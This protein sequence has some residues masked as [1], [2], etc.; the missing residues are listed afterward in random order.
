MGLRDGAQGVGNDFRDIGYSEEQEGSEAC[1][2]RAIC[3]PG[4]FYSKWA[5][6]AEI[7]T[8]SFLMGQ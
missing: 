3:L 1:E 2:Q 6:H 5:C 7:Y 4:I 8:I